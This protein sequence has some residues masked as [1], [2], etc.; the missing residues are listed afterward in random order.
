[1]SRALRNHPDVKKETRKLV[2]NMARKLE[3]QP[4][5]VAKSFR[6]RRS[7]I[8]GL[9]VPNIH[10]HFF[11][12]IIS[13]FTDLAYAKG[14]TVMTCQSNDDAEHEHRIIESLIQNRV[15]GVV[16]SIAQ[17]SCNPD[18]YAML[19]A[20][21]IPLVFFDRFCKDLPVP[22][23]STDNALG[24]SMAVEH[25]VKR[26]R[27][28]IA[29]ITGNAAINVFAER[30]QGYH[31]ALRS[32]GM[33][34]DPEWVVETGTETEHGYAAARKLMENGTPPDALVTVSFAQ[35]CG[36]LKYLREKNVGIPDQVAIVTFG[37]DPV[38]S[39]LTPALTTISQTRT[40]M[41]KR[42]FELLYGQIKSA[43][44]PKPE[45]LRL[46]PELIIRDSS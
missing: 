21:G 18:P 2:L 10:H 37:E 25:L 16:A 46:K 1:V 41:A 24:A 34:T 28:K 35:G 7:T 13:T 29:L 14:F 36:V 44:N 23:V 40:H 5:V 3:Y 8:I 38:N 42:S 45:I 33:A 32:F 9:I 11:S 43:E 19:Q 12:H 20:R 30:T 39:L 6:T 27:K 26:G 22:K 15:A 4:S 17:N 31:E